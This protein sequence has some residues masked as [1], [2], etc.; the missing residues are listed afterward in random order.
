MNPL[1]LEKAQ[2]LKGLVNELNQ[3]KRG[4][5]G[6]IVERA[7]EYLCCSKDK[8][9]KQLS[10]FGYQEERKARADKGQI[11]I[12]RNDAQILSGLIRHSSRDTGKVLMSVEQAVDIAYAND[13]IGEMYSKSTVLRAFDKYK[14][15]PKQVKGMETTRSMRSLHPNHTCQFDVSICVLYY[16]KNHKGL[17]AMPES[18]FY[19]NKPHNLEKV[20]NERVLRYLMTDHYSGAFFLRYYVAAGENTETITRFLFEAFCERNSGEL[21]YGVPMVL[22]WD[23]GSANI[24]HQTRHLLD[25]L[26]VTH[27]AHTPGKPWAKGQ[28]ESTHNIIEKQFEGRLA[29]MPINSIEELNEAA[30]A[31]SVNFQ[32]TK[33]HSRHNQTRYGMW[34]TIRQEQLRLIPDVELVKG[35]MQQTKPDTR[36]VSSHDLAITFAP[37]GYGSQRYS[38][39]QIPHICSG[40]EVE[41]YVNPYSAPDIRVKSTDEYGE[42]HVHEVK[43]IE[44]DQAGF[45]ITAPVYG[46][47]YASTRDTQIDKSRAELDVQAWGTDNNRE[48]KKARKSGKSVAYNGEINPMADVEQTTAPAHMKRKGTSMHIEPTTKVTEPKLTVT[49][50]LKKLRAALKPTSKEME[51]INKVVK[52]RF[53]EGATESEIDTFIQQW[54]QGYDNYTQANAQ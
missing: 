5:K 49:G 46:E 30:Q 38:L 8:L 10:Q 29:F 20:K 40:D 23:A 47:N 44:V 7:C 14:L 41:V 36:T 19:K 33:L 16:L 13:R 17:R 22:I 48:I 51:T 54:E 50:T 9:Y 31:W 34:Q 32:S 21:V 25:L 26:Q 53:P 6:S 28:V 18:E 3:A 42:E 24:A 15:H 45:D 11:G 27:I 1:E 37:K 43:A 52:A 12:S 39:S 2:Y 4:E 35:M